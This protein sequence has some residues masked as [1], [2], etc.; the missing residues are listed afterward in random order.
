MKNCF[1]AAKR[2]T[3]QLQNDFEPKKVTKTRKD[4]SVN[5][6]WSRSDLV[7]IRQQSKFKQLRESTL[8][9]GRK[10]LDVMSRRINWVNTA[11]EGTNLYVKIEQG[12]APAGPAATTEGGR[13]GSWTVKQ[14]PG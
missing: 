14:R 10:Y 3:T 1:L 6:N 5:K 13:I 12:S 11:E 9:L 8:I 4:I 2:S 7:H